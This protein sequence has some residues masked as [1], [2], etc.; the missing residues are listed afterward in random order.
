[1]ARCT[2]PWDAETPPLD[3]EHVTIAVSGAHGGHTVDF[4]YP[5][6]RGIELVG[7]TASYESGTLRFASDL[8]EN[9]ARGDA[10]YMSL[11]DEAD[12]YVARNG[13]DLPEEPEARMCA[14][15]FTRTRSA[16]ARCGSI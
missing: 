3:A 5:A 6:A 16:I 4:R 14:S 15:R 9:I 12:A 2:G 11:L 8:S 1:V 10:N 13:R 7:L